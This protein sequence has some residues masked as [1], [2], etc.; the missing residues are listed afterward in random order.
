MTTLPVTIPVTVTIAP[1]LAS[2]PFAIR[3]HFLSPRNRSIHDV[4]GVF[5]LINPNNV[6]TLQ[7]ML[8]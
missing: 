1:V 3:T 6:K 5:V 7:D 4:D 2:H 8:E